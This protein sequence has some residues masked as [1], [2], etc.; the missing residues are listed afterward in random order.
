MSGEVIP[1]NM[2]EY[3]E[4]IRSDPSTL[5]SFVVEDRARCPL[6]ILEEVTK[7]LH[8]ADSMKMEDLWRVSTALSKQPEDRSA[9]YL[10][11]ACLKNVS[12]FSEEK[13]DHYAF[14][15]F[16]NWEKYLEHDTERD[17]KRGFAMCMGLFREELPVVD[18][19]YPMESDTALRLTA[20]LSH[21]VA[22]DSMYSKVRLDQDKIGGL[23]RDVMLQ[24][25]D[26]SV[27]DV[28][29]LLLGFRAPLEWMLTVSNTV[30]PRAEQFVKQY[31]K[32]A[33]ACCSLPNARLD[34]IIGCA[35]L[36]LMG[37]FPDESTE[38]LLPEELPRDLEN[39]PAPEVAQDMHTRH[40]RL[41]KDKGF[42]DNDK[43]SHSSP[44]HKTKQDF[45]EFMEDVKSSDGMEP[46]FVMEAL[47]VCRSLSE[48]VGDGQMG[49]LESPSQNS[50]DQPPKPASR[51][52][53]QKD[54]DCQLEKKRRC[55]EFVRARATKECHTNVEWRDIVKG[56]PIGQKP[57]GR[58]PPV[59]IR[60]NHS[61]VVKGPVS[62]YDKALNAKCMTRLAREV[63]RL[64]HCIPEVRVIA[65]CDDKIGLWSPMIGKRGPD[66]GE[67]VVAS[68]ETR[69][70][71]K[72]HEYPGNWMKTL[73]DPLDVLKIVVA[74]NI[75]GSSD[76]NTSNILVEYD[77]GRVYGLDVGG[78]RKRALQAIGSSF[79]WAFSKKVSVSVLQKMECLVKQYAAQMMSWLEGL[80][81]VVTMQRWHQVIA[82]YPTRVSVPD[83]REGVDLFYNFFLS[84]T[85]L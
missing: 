31:L 14:D 20:A 27:K 10:S 76:N 33:V 36:A 13:K 16:T 77:T 25:I 2:S 34:L 18:H 85:L 52:R 47:Q 70:L 69:G 68:N 30:P 59:F 40:G 55:I 42:L 72:L 62:Q 28:R 21:L 1:R 50:D 29:P 4:A 15:P 8:R 22:W 11:V 41:A 9:L 51:K 19:V 35:I 71:C 58:K 46:A 83:L 39:S 12:P 60:M 43:C 23:P 44:H 26:E 75:V 81:S 63:L 67:G 6:A 57:C 17:A 3:L 61:E 64:E 56:C 54:E 73:V 82:E 66:L 38:V 80:K 65:F 84:Q 49:S 7:L 5:L 74:K 53:K 37:R 32:M 45:K 48:E 79:Q 24:E 78:E